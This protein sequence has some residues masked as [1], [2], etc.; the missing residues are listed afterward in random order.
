MSIFCPLLLYALPPLFVDVFYGWPLVFYSSS[1]AGTRKWREGRPVASHAYSRGLRGGLNIRAYALRRMA[2]GR[3]GGGSGRGSPPTGSRGSG[4][5]PPEN[6][7]ETE[8][9]VGAFL[10]IQ[11]EIL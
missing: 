8:T 9:S 5:L 11:K 4:V 6:F 7:L 3:V 10:R 1:G 2:Y